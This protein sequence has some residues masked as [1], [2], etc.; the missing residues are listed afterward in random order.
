M[1]PE[2]P[3]AISYKNFSVGPHVV[4]FLRSCSS[5]LTWYMDYWVVTGPLNDGWKI[6]RCKQC[7]ALINSILSG[8]CAVV[9]AASDNRRFDAWDNVLLCTY[10]IFHKKNCHLNDFW[11]TAKVSNFCFKKKQKK[12][13]KM[14][15]LVITVLGHFYQRH[16]KKND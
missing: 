2:L 10:W 6:R 9:R 5:L 8:P 13:E 16:S 15:L 4:C 12:N 3:T 1:Q 11:I 7:L 14:K